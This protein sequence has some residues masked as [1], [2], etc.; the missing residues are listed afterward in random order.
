[1]GSRDGSQGGTYQKLAMTFRTR[2]LKFSHSYSHT[3][4]YLLS[5]LE[6][7]TIKSQGK[8]SRVMLKSMTSLIPER[9]LVSLR[10]LGQIQ[11]KTWKVRNLLGHKCSETFDQGKAGWEQLREH[12]ANNENFNSLTVQQIFIEFLVSSGRI[13]GFVDIA[14]NL[15]GERWSRA[16]SSWQQVLPLTLR[17]SKW[18]PRLWPLSSICGKEK[19]FR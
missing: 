12:F 9:L 14:I 1:M 8:P 10:P 4:Q 16:G 11:V 6:F 7:T 17:A 15:E 2:L 3:V 18:L 13:E 19:I 5:I